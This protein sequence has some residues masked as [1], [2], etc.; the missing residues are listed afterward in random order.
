[1]FSVSMVLEV[2]YC[3]ISSMQ[4]KEVGTCLSS[5]C[6]VRLSLIVNLS[7]DIKMC[8]ILVLLI[9]ICIIVIFDDNK[10]QV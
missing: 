3:D 9:Y 4:S 6:G 10:K 5:K 7:T 1:M 8:R 2:Y